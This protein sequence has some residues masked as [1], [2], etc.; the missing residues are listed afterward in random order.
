[1]NAAFQLTEAPYV[2]LL[3][4]DAAPMPTYTGRLLA[5][6][7]RTSTPVAA[8]TGR[9]VRPPEEGFGISR[10]QHEARL[11]DACGMVLT[12]NW[13]H[14]DRGSGD[15]DHGQWNVAER[16]F[17][18]TGAASLFSRAALE[19]V[20]ISDDV[21]DPAFHSYREDAELCFRFHER[22]WEVIYEPGA[23]AVHRRRVVPERRGQLPEAIN[24]HSL[25]NRYLL[26]VYHQTARNFL[27]TGLQATFRDLQALVYVLLF[28]RSSLPAYTWLWRHRHEILARRRLIQSRRTA[29]PAAVDQWFAGTGLPL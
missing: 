25:K 21:F 16:V 2:L 7:R 17:G 5:R 1:M 8:V 19:D 26:R 11:V 15:L 20:K 12:R 27:R 10:L 6:M 18:A 13:R 28:E 9:L 23:I 14:L 24:Y 29:A 22:G 3:N 4:P